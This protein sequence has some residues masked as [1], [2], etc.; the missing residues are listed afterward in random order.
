MK[1]DNKW[2]DTNARNLPELKTGDTVW[3][4][5]NKSWDSKAQVKEQCNTPRSFKSEDRKW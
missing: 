2:Y 3:I 1:S 5:G 4:Q